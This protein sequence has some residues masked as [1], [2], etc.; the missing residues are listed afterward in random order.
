MPDHSLDQPSP[1]DSIPPDPWREAAVPA[2]TRHIDGML[3]G[4]VGAILAPE[5]LDLRQDTAAVPYLFW[6][7]EV[8]QILPR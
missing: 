3:R 7:F 5:L 1:S 6:N 2:L 8:V 4:N